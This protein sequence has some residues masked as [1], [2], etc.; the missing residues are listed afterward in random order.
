[1]LSFLPI[2]SLGLSTFAGYNTKENSPMT[3]GMGL[4]RDKNG[5]YYP[6]FQRVKQGDWRF[7]NYDMDTSYLIP[8]VNAYE[9]DGAFSGPGANLDIAMIA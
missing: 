9:S 8:E 1:M 2:Y 5:Y 7:Q 3:P 6:E 4:N